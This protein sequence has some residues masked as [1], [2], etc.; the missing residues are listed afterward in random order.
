MVFADDAAVLVVDA[1]EALAA[2]DGEAVE[3]G[4]GGEGGVEI[5]RAD[6]VDGELEDIAGACGGLVDGGGDIPVVVLRERRGRREEGQVKRALWAWEGGADAGED[7]RQLEDGRGAEVATHREDHQSLRGELSSASG[8]RRWM[9]RSRRSSS[10]RRSSVS[11]W[12]RCSPSGSPGVPWPSG[13]A[14]LGGWSPWFCGSSCG[15]WGCGLLLGDPAA[16]TLGGLWAV[17]LAAAAAL[18]YRPYL[19]RRC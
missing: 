9:P 4:L 6:D 2:S 3:G 18:V 10:S 8:S 1:G 15:S 12:R 11:S 7:E 5:A 16:R 19:V 17:R 13:G 14:R